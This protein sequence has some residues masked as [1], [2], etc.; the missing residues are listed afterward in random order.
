MGDAYRGARLH[1]DERFP[2]V[3]CVCRNPSPM[4]HCTL[5]DGS[6]SHFHTRCL[7]SGLLLHAT[8][9]GCYQDLIPGFA[10]SMHRVPGLGEATY[11]K[12]LDDRLKR[13]CADVA[14]RLESSAASPREVGLFLDSQSQVAAQLECHVCLDKVAYRPV[15]TGCHVFCQ[16]CWT[17]WVLSTTSPTSRVSVTCPACREPVRLTTVVRS[18]RLLQRLIGCLQVKCSNHALGCSAVMSYGVD[19][20][21]L[22]AH[23]QHCPFSPTSCLHCTWTGPRSHQ[24][25][26]ACAPPK[27]VCP[28]P[29]CQFVDTPANVARHVQRCQYTVLHC[30]TCNEDYPRHK[31]AYHQQQDCVYRCVHCHRY[32][33]ESKRASHQQNPKYRL[34]YNFNPCENG[35]GQPVLRGVHSKHDETC[36]EAS[37]TCNACSAQCKRK[38]IEKHW[39]KVH[40]DDMD[41]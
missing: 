33:A 25:S 39:D 27:S 29:G 10:E 8:A 35:C 14:Q 20:E 12:T 7:P 13:D 41:Y 6:V 15:S 5:A 31:A 18:D 28:N 19:G 4:F 22:R 16:H 2:G 1:I 26:H 37:V 21:G 9:Y 30:T 11:L 38:N 36:P 32:I 40:H 3:C 17:S 34:C 24:A 23:L